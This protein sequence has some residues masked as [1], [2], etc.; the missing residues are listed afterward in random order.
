MRA[1]LR[2]PPVCARQPSPRAHRPLAARR[3]RNPEN[4]DALDVDP[5]GWRY[6]DNAW[7]KM[8]KKAGL[9]K[10]TRRRRWVRRAA[11]VEVVER[12]YEPK[13][14]ELEAALKA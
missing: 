11:L 8:S 14:H 3:G 5:D 7:D 1:A 12:G 6:G 10:Y 13:Q 2:L 9:G 4:A